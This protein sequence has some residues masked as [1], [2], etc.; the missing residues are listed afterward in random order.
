MFTD[1]FGDETMT[2]HELAKMLLALPDL[3]VYTEGCDCSG[4]AWDVEHSPATEH[5]IE[6]LYIKRYHVPVR[7]K[8]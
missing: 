5:M 7:P 6:Y 8:E 4:E 2:A 1:E 3:P